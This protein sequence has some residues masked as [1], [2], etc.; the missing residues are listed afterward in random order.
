MQLSPLIA[1]VISTESIY[2]LACRL[3]TTT[4]KIS[5]VLA[6]PPLLIK[7]FLSSRLSSRPRTPFLRGFKQLADFTG[8]SCT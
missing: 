7:L 3:N 2:N 1:A 6:S 8:L 5:A 4:A